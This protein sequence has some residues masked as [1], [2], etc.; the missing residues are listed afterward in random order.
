MIKSIQSADELVEMLF[1]IARKDKSRRVKKLQE[2][3]FVD[4]KVRREI[5]TSVE[6]GRINLEGMFYTINFENKG[7]GV[8]RAFVEFKEPL[9][10]GE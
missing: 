10:G 1:N 7:G 3:W 9:E 8:H 5:M 4:T 2:G 6:Q